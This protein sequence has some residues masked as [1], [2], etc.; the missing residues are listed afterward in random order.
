MG[1]RGVMRNHSNT[2]SLA[3]S[4]AGT[5]ILEVMFA[6]FVVIVGL[7][8]IASIL[9]LAARNAS[10]SNAHNNAQALGQRWFASFTA[11]RLNEPNAFSSKQ[12]GYD[13]YWFRDNASPGFQVFSHLN[14]PPASLPTSSVWANQSICIDPMFYSEPS[15]RA[16]I[17]ETAGLDAGY[18]LAVF[19]Y[20][21]DTYDPLDDPL[22]TSSSLP[23]QPRM[24]RTTL[25]L[26][27]TNIASRKLVEDIFAS[28][29]DVAFDADETDNT[30]AAYRLFDASQAKAL[31]NGQYSWL[32]TLAPI[33]P[34]SNINDLTPTYIL[35]LVVMNRRDREY[36]ATPLPAPGDAEAKPAGE[37]LVSVLPLSGNFQNG[38]GGRVRLMANA[39][40][41]DVVH[42]GDWIMLGGYSPV[43]GS[44]AKFR[45]YRIIAMN[46]Q[47]TLSS[48]AWSRDVVLEGPDFE[49][50]ATGAQGTLMS[51]V[52]TVVERNVMVRW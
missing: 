6:I 5:T 31:A 35:S 33:E 8:G 25:G 28:P 21:R 12:L 24:L 22:A 32:A 9:P 52:V 41:S 47:P 10:D 50:P 19:P 37:R 16:R 38:T 1:K 39:Q 48:G 51:G 30:Q 34:F 2:N 44:F 42:I 23:P 13:W 45:W 20:Y 36:L 40:T 26:S 18:R 43:G 17:A 14:N 4:R 46:Q 49:F 15:V 29:D 27:S 3:Q 7:L 11:L